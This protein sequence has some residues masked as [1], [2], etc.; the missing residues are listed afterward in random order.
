M[1]VKLCARGVHI[2]YAED[3]LKVMLPCSDTGTTTKFQDHFSA[4]DN[5]FSGLINRLPTI[6]TECQINILALDYYILVKPG[7][8]PDIHRCTKWISFTEAIQNQ[9]ELSSL[10]QAALKKL[11][12][13]LNY[14]PIEYHLL[15]GKFT[16][17][18][19]RVLYE[20][21]L[22]KK[23]DRGNFARKMGIADFL[24]PEGLKTDAESTKAPMLYTF[25]QNYFRKTEQGL[26]KEF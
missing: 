13:D 14:Q 12:E 1:V 23:L 24:Q 16:M 7:E 11:K 20:L 2:S 26:F 6:S 10:V 19:L 3:E 17:R 8:R 15:P 9:D 18:E 22:G 21:I 4:S 25:N 5:S